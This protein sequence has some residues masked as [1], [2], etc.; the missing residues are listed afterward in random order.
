M[1]LYDAIQ[2]KLTAVLTKELLPKLA[3]AAT[4]IALNL[5]DEPPSKDSINILFEDAFRKVLDSPKTTKTSPKSKTTSGKKKQ[6]KD[7]VPTKPQKSKWID[8]AAMKQQLQESDGKKY[9]CGF[10]ADRGPHKRMFCGVELIGLNCGTMSD[11]KQWTPHSPEEEKAA[12][13]TMRDLRCKNCWA[14]GKN[15]AYRKKGGFTKFYSDELISDEPEPEPEPTEDPPQSP[16]YN[17]YPEDSLPEPTTPT[18]SPPETDNED[19]GTF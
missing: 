16:T 2:Q 12:V 1:S 6:S 18:E 9:F 3:E 15:G 17:P 4:E 11:D 8:L 13:E 10:V 14:V 7:S 19:D 5:G